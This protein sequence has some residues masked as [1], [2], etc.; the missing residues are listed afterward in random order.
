MGDL[1]DPV[2]LRGGGTVR[3]QLDAGTAVEARAY[4]VVLHLTPLPGKFGI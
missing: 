3:M 4:L 1:L 2:P